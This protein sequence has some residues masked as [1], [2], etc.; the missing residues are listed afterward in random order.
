MTAPLALAA[1]RTQQSQLEDTFVTAIFLTVV[2]SGLQSQGH[3]FTQNSH[4]DTHTLLNGI[5]W[6]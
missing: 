4:K 6:P 2:E 1:Q 3:T 5:T